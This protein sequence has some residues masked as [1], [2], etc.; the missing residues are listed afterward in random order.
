[1]VRLADRIS[2]PLLL[3]LAPATRTTRASVL[4]ALPARSIRRS[5]PVAP[6]VRTRPLAPA[7]SLTGSAQATATT[8]LG[9]AGNF[10]VLAGS[11]I[12]NTGATDLSTAYTY[13]A[14]QPATL[15][16]TELANQTL[17][18][19]VYRSA[20]G[21]LA[22]TGTLVLDGANKPTGVWIF[23]AASALVTGGT[24]NVR[25][26]RGANACDVFYQVGSAATLGAGST[27]TGAILAHDTISV[28]NGVTVQGRLLAGEQAS[29]AGAVTLIHDTIISPLCTPPGTTPPGTTPPGTTPPGTAPTGP[30]GT[31][32]PTGS[33]T[34]P[35]GATPPGAA[36]VGSSTTRSTTPDVTLATTTTPRAGTRSTTTPPDRGGDH[37]WS[38]GQAGPGG[39][40]PHR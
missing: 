31:S 36:P 7:A 37:R 26:I 2:L 30:A 3:P 25:L 40:G 5:A 12:T 22:M 4:A 38:A 33:G 16:A 13:A 21:T 32:T 29:G 28:G 10:A 8:V 27:L 1:M 24:G 34:T 19:G 39:R 14:A 17:T 23:Q 6:A 35:T 15:I 9:T 20:S 18:A 11:G